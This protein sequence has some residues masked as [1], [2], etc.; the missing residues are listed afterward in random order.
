MVENRTLY[1]P[2]VFTV[3]F[4]TVSIRRRTKTVFFLRVGLPVCGFWPI[5]GWGRGFEW[6]RGHARSIKQ[7]TP[8]FGG[9]LLG[10]IPIV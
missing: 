8:E 4:S 6:G 3:R 2:V 9:N 1:L 7:I 5:F 10:K